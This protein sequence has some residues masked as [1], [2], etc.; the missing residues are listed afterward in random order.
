M[1]QNGSKNRKNSRRKNK[2][3]GEKN[4]D[5]DHLFDLNKGHMQRT[6]NPAPRKRAVNSARAALRRRARQSV[7]GYFSYD[8]VGN[9]LADALRTDYAYNG[10]HQLTADS[11]YTYGYDNNGNLTSRTNKASS[12][13]AN[14]TYDSQNRL[15]Q[16]VTE[17]GITATYRYDV[18]GRRIAKTVSGGEAVPGFSGSVRYIYDNSD[19]IGLVDNNNSIAAVITH[20]PGV[21][22]PLMIAAGGQK[23]FILSDGLGSVAA[24]ADANGNIK[25]RAIYHA[26]GKPVFID[27]QTGQTLASSQIPGNIYSYTGRE[28]DAETGLFYYRARYYDADAG[29]FI[30]KDPIGFNGGDV[31]LYAYVQNNPASMTDPAGTAGMYIDYPD[32]RVN[33]GYGTYPLGHG[34]VVA[35]NSQTGMT[36]YYEYGRYNENSLGEVR[37]PRVPNLIMDNGVPTK[38]SMDNLLQYLSKNMGH[39]GRVSATYYSKADA[40]KII[41]FAEHRMHDPNR[42]SYGILTNN[43]KTFGHDAIMAG[44]GN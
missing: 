5:S 22:E 4:R 40:G 23:Y 36:K 43:C 27:A 42:A 31:N 19:A 24:V 11:A 17:G 33:T 26:Y 21:D 9:R 30:Q 41:A 28:Y 8:A 37:N 38:A 29:R 25:E 2:K 1:Y 12:I 10:G 6:L 44:G 14:Y 18:M 3:I 35:V 7:R 15:K 13:T 32:Y 39:N 16:A 20:G 34:A